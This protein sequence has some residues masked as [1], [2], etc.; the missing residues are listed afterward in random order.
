MIKLDIAIF[1]FY[2]IS[3]LT[4]NKNF[5]M[6]MLIIHKLESTRGKNQIEQNNYISQQKKHRDGF[7]QDIEN[8]RN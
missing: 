8:L 7:L 6:K 4:Y 3:L 2:I 5:K 1:Y